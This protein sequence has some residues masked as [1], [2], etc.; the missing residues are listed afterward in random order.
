MTRERLGGTMRT[1]MFGVFVDVESR[2]SFSGGGDQ[3]AE[4]EIGARQRSTGDGKKHI[5]SSI[6][7][8]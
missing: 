6:W 2:L 8:L 4:G 3:L 7:G 5:V 1:A